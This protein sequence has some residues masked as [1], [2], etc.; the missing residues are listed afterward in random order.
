MN[1]PL[2]ALAIAGAGIAV[3]RLITREVETTLRRNGVDPSVAPFAAAGI[4]ALG[5]WA[6]K[7]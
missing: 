1:T 3:R 7:K 2:A 4:V 6:L 5:I